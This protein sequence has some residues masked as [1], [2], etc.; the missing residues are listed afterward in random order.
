M[1]YICLGLLTFGDSILIFI[2]IYGWFDLWCSLRNF[3][4]FCYLLQLRYDHK[5]F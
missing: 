5:I 4:T 1:S 3:N 2:V